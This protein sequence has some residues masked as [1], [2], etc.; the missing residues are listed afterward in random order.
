VFGS[1]ER[2]ATGIHIVDNTLCI[3]QIV[4]VEEVTELHALVQHAL[5]G[6]IEPGRLDGA[7]GTE[8]LIQVLRQ[9]QQDRGLSFE[10]PVMALPQDAFYLKSRPLVVAGEKANREHL[11][12]ETKQVLAGDPDAY[13]IDFALT[14]HCGF[15][16]AAHRRVLD[17]Y[18]DVCTQSGIKNPDFDIPPFALYNAMEV[19]DLLAAE[20][21]ALALDIEPLR[22]CAILVRGG[23][24][25]GVASCSWDEGA[26]MSARVSDLE[27]RLGVLLEEGDEAERPQRMWIAGTAAIESQWSL[28]LAE[29]LGMS[30]ALMDPF[31]GIDISPL[32]SVDASLLSSRSKFAISAG[33]AFRGLFL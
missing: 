5:S 26:E 15:V 23:E 6:P 32:D 20:K 22:A 2:T 13:S 21:V 19:A 30:G 25:A 29:K 7:G 1:K 16:V 17:L 9:L 3:V 14:R 11:L 10:N 31:R 27:E 33:L 4:G 28:E 12:W 8:E 18:L 24:M